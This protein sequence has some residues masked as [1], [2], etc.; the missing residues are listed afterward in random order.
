MTDGRKNGG[1]QGENW[2]HENGNTLMVQSEKGE[3]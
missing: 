2:E 3:A 1:T